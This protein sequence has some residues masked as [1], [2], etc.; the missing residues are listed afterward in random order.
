ME[1]HMFKENENV[2][3]NVAGPKPTLEVTAESVTQGA[4]TWLG[5]MRPGRP[6]KSIRK[7]QSREI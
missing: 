6:R 3:R 4:N 1:H 7:P 2:L 5:D